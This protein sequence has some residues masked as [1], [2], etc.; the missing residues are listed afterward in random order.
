MSAFLHAFTEFAGA[1]LVLAFA[2]AIFL[3]LVC[4]ARDIWREARG[5]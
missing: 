3:G 5:Q 4:W 2:G 1:C